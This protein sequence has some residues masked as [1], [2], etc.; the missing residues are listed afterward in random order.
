[1][2]SL[3]DR[4]G[5]GL[6]DGKYGYHLDMRPKKIERKRKALSEREWA[7]VDVRCKAS[8]VH[9]AAEGLHVSVTVAGRGAGGGLVMAG[10]GEPW[11]KR[12]LA[13]AREG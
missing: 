4:E 9:S 5:R 10:E 2:Q 8:D 6:R 13:R 12:L 11:V 3:Q 1:M 7:K